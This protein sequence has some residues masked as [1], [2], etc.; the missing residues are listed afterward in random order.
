MHSVKAVVISFY[1]LLFAS[2]QTYAQTN[3]QSSAALLVIDVQNCFVDGGSLPVPSGAEVI[4][5]INKIAPFFQNIV[6]TQDW[7]PAGHI[8]FASSHPGAIPF[9]VIKLPY[10]EQILWPDH[11]IQGS[12]D[13]L[14]HP[15]LNLPNAQ[16]ILRKGFHKEVDSYSAFLE[17]DRNTSTGL[18]AYLRDRQIDAVYIAGLATDFCVA[19]TAL[20]AHDAGFSVYVVEDATRAIN[21]GKPLES[22]WHSLTSRGVNRIQSEEIYVK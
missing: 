20:D 19:W 16:L 22:V 11:C 5:V 15:M 14:L 18:A 1:F 12:S 8:S 7:H 4:P 17:A 2:S 21:S 3:F 10:G 13:A 9:E 6:V